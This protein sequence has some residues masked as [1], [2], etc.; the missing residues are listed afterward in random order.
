MIGCGGATNCSLEQAHFAVRF[1]VGNVPATQ[2]R[3]TAAPIPSTAPTSP[4]MVMTTVPTAEVA[5][6]TAPATLLASRLPS[7]TGASAIVVATD[8]DK[9]RTLTLAINDRL[10][11]QLASTKWL[12]DAVGSGGPLESLGEPEKIDMR[13]AMDCVAG[14]GCGTTTVRFVA[15]AA[16]YQLPSPRTGD[17]AAKP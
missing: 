14:Q 3:S 12:F 6:V 10:V 16:W 2:M 4:S 17:R 13:E 7:T 1:V 15:V 8:A 11:V 5:P 9:W